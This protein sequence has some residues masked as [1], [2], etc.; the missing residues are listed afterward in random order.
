MSQLKPLLVGQ[1]PGWRGDGEPLSGD[2]G[3][4]LSALCGMSLDD[5]LA[6]F[7]RVNAGEIYPGKAGRGDALPAVPP[8]RVEALV[9]MMLARRRVV[10]LG[11]HVARVLGYA[12]EPLFAWDEPFGPFTRIAVVPHPSGRSRW[13]NSAENRAQAKAF[14]RSLAA[15]K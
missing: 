13:W 3:R 2:A 12:R 1:A 15:L 8:E 6:R 10:L 7:D 9:V 11:R 4:R 14:F 5:F